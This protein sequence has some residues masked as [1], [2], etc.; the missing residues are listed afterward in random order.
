L[1]A[2]ARTFWR[3][4]LWLVDFL[5]SKV[6]DV[7]TGVAGFVI[8]KAVKTFTLYFF[9]PVVFLIVLLLYDIFKE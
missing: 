5:V 2:R 1:G 3:G 7:I 4:V 6:I 9:V 8:D